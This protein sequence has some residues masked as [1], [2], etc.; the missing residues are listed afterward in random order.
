[1]LI[2]RDVPVSLHAGDM[3]WTF[4]STINALCWSCFRVFS[5]QSLLH[6]IG[7]L[8]FVIWIALLCFA[9]I[10]RLCT[11]RPIKPK[12]CSTPRQNNIHDGFS[13]CKLGVRSIFKIV[14]AQSDVLRTQ[15]PRKLENVDKVYQILSTVLLHIV[16]VCVCLRWWNCSVGWCHVV[17]LLPAATVIFDRSNRF[18]PLVAVFGFGSQ[19]PKSCSSL[20]KNM[21]SIYLKKIDVKTG[22][23]AFEVLSWSHNVRFFWGL[24]NI[25]WRCLQMSP[26]LTQLDQALLPVPCSMCQGSCELIWGLGLGLDGCSTLICLVFKFGWGVFKHLNPD[27]VDS[28]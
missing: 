1:M 20:A 8:G 15:W 6:L 21:M 25:V 7:L 3:F 10:T 4:R 24:Q 19:K 14:Q 28:S 2:F 26:A 27:L 16:W 5:G 23:L 13:G 12:F 17:S 18:L 22:C 9:G 11:C